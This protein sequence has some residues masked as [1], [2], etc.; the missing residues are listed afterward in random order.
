M[1]PMEG[2]MCSGGNQ[3]RQGHGFADQLALDDVTTERL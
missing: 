2:P 1:H 3:I